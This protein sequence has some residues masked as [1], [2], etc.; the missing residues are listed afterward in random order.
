MFGLCCWMLRISTIKRA[1]E[2]KTCGLTLDLLSA[3]RV[4]L[5]KSF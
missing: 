4:T 3:N 2:W 5:E 1:L